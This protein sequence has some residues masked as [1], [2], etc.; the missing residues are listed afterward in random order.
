MKERFLS[1]W[2]QSFELRAFFE[3]IPSLSACGGRAF[4]ISLQGCQN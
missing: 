2:L 4:V 1:L 3:D